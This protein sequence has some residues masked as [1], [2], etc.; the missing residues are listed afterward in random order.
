MPPSSV[1]PRSGREDATR[2][3]GMHSVRIIQISVIPSATLFSSVIP[4]GTEW[5]AGIGRGQHISADPRVVPAALLRMTMQKESSHCRF[6]RLLGMT[7]R[8]VIPNGTEWSAGIGRGQHIPA[9]PHV[10]PAALLR[11]TMQKESS[12]RRFQRLLG[13]TIRS[14]I[15]SERQ[16]AR[17]SDADGTSQP[18]LASGLRPSSG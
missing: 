10:V 9:D 8:S 2:E 12:R 6:Q 16:R 7:I 1:I 18:I 17:E 14:V 11:M 4:S 15:P 5:S 13:M 3:S